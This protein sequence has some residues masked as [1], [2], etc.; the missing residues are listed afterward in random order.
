MLMSVI[1]HLSIL[2]QKTVSFDKLY[3][4]ESLLD[5]NWYNRSTV[6]QMAER[7]S[8]D[9]RVMGSNLT[10]FTSLLDL[11]HTEIGSI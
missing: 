9:L 8:H 6:A 4:T 2:R 5:N 1:V 3:N 11:H 7:V 10:W